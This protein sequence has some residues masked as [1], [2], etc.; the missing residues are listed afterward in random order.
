MLF[1]DCSSF[2]MFGWIIGYPVFCQSLNESLMRILL[3]RQMK[4][5]L[6]ND[7]SF[8]YLFDAE[9]LFIAY[10]C[11]CCSLCSLI[12]WVFSV[13]LLIIFSF[14]NLINLFC[15]MSL[16]ILIIITSP[17]QSNLRRVRCF[18]ADKI[19]SPFFVT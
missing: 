10:A 3:A 6:K 13:L 5:V 12:V 17:P 8:D 15:V 18:S 1:A 4:V 14:R 9:S 7:L 19:T 2:L 16:I 11:C